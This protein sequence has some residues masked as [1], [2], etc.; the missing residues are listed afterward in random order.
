MELSK[1]ING[2]KMAAVDKTSMLY[3][4]SFY[5]DGVLTHITKAFT[6]EEAEQL[7]ENYVQGY[8]P[9]SFLTESVIN[10]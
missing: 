3:E 10:G 4:V 6:E 8:G 1:Y 5:K 9:Q 7:A 2:G